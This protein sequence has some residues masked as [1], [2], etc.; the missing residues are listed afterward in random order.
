MASDNATHP[1]R[2]MTEERARVTR[3]WTLPTK[4]IVGVS[5]AMFLVQ[6]AWYAS[7]AIPIIKGRQGQGHGGDEEQLTA[8]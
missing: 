7:G 2:S 5:L 1:S 8:P 6:L 3:G 4:I